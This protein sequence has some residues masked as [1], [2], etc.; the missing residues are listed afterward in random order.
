VT[1]GTAVRSRRQAR[2]THA[3]TDSRGPYAHAPRPHRPPPDRRRHARHR[4]CSRMAHPTDAVRAL[5]LSFPSHHVLPAGIETRE[6]QAPVLRSSSP[7]PALR[8]LLRLDAA[9]GGLHPSAEL[10]P[11]SPRASGGTTSGNLDGSGF[12][13]NTFRR[14]EGEVLGGHARGHGLLACAR[15]ARCA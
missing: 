11:T 6:H 2:R 8:L 13:L 7:S 1:A 9:A 5:T 3:G 4:S 10:P 15:L 12:V 14:L